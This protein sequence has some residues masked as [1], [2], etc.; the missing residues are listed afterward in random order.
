M[1]SK[2]SYAI[3]LLLLLSIQV[4]AQKATKNINPMKN[5]KVLI[6]VTSFGEVGNGAKTGIWLE[7]FTTPYYLLT[8]KGFKVTV[9][10]PA[11]GKAPIDPKSTI[12]DYAT[13]SVKRFL[14][15]PAAQQILNKTLNLKTIQAKDYDAI[16]YPGGHGPMWDLPQNSYSIS[17]IESFFNEGKPIAFVCHAPAALKN[18]KGKDGE[19]LIKGKIIAGFTNSEEEA[20]QST[21]LVP[22][23]LENML[24]DRGAK[25]V[26]GKDWEPFAVQDG[27]LITGQNPASADLVAKKIITILSK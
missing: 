10:S 16:F 12:G 15:D 7:E 8:A 25:Y 13:A 19:Y 20:G 4:F 14:T 22:F 5:K 2:P 23:S 9:A 3:I 18:V 1:K 26:K 27:N 11:G 24:K 21:N 6:V 17:L